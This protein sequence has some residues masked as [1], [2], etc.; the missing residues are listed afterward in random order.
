MRVLLLNAPPIKKLGIT[1]QIYPPLGILYLASYARAH[2]DNLEI[3]AI[4]GYRQDKKG[5]VDEIVKYQPDVLGVSFTTQA[6]TGAYKLINEVKAMNERIMVACGGPHPT[7]MPAES[8]QQS[9]AD[10]VVIGE[11]E[12]SFV[13]I[14]QRLA[15]GEPLTCIQGTAVSINGRFHKNPPR[16]LIDDLDSIPFPA[17]DLLDITKYPGYLYKKYRYDTDIISARGCPF[18][19]VYCSNPVWKLQKPWYRLRSPKNVVD[20]M[21]AVVAEYGIREIFDETDEFNGSKRWAKAVCDEIVSRGLD[22]AW[23]AQMRVDNI[24]EELADKLRR[25]GFWLALFGLES[26]NE[27]TLKGI[28]KQQTLAQMERA[29]GIMQQRGIKCF[30]L[31]MAFN[32]WEGDGRLCYESKEDSLNTL[33]YIKRL[34]K[35][36]R[37]DIFAWSMTTPY[38][39]SRLYDV[40]VKYDLIDDSG[41]GGWE[42]FDSGANFLLKLPTVSERDWLEVMNAGKRLQARQ[43]LASGSF[44]LSALP[45][46]LKKGYSLAKRN[47]ERLLT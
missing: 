28:N 11:G 40:A 6:A 32:V 10:I 43:L 4:D 27:K 46:Y 38:P 1:G 25:A 29:L 9:R 36:K 31:F 17:R 22:I 34:I 39:G 47:V 42:N 37:L 7:I 16:P 12:V 21:E 26:A 20:E 2:I 3:R 15:G 5:L 45:L 19:C 35:E 33:A 30:G 44:N 14:L 24:D 8:F 13:E 23:K 18:N 41:G